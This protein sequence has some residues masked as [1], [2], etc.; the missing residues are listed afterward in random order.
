MIWFYKSLSY[1]SF[2]QKLIITIIIIIII[3]LANDNW[4]QPLFLAGGHTYTHA[5]YVW[6]H[7]HRYIHN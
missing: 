5:N 2:D 4:L 1:F 7:I 6:L 3:N